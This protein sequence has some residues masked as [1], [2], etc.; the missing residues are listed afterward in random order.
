M[1][2]S[3]SATSYARRLL[4]A[5]RDRVPMSPLTD[6]RPDLSEED[7]YGIQEALVAARGGERVGYKLGFTSAAMRE[8]MGI[9]SP[10]YGRLT[11][12]MCVE[13]GPIDPSGLIH[14]RVEPELALLIE[15]DLRGPGLTVAAAS[16]AVRW[17]FG[18]V[19]VV[20]SRFADY[21]FR[22]AD[23]TADNS[24]AARFVLGPGAPLGSVPDLRL[25]GAL[26][27]CGGRVVDR[28]VGADAL[29][30]PFSALAWLANRLGERGLI[31]ETGSV[32]LTG[33]LTRAY[34][35][36]GGGTF[37]AE[38]AGLGAAKVHFEGDGAHLQNGAPGT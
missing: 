36:G 31:L 19:E 25:C 9:P 13:A 2:S 34:P 32:V 11:T 4:E 22:A 15:K 16:A 26:L 23:N 30:S 5:E 3:P 33:G 1:L 14:P 21:R 6:S 12:D 29:G 7:S 28:G 24:S 8:Q 10:N 35:V 38:F 37:V 27:W 18:A 20:D 17:V